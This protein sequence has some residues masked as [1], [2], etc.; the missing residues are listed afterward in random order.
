T[1]RL[2]IEDPFA[3]A[4]ASLVQG[5]RQALVVYPRLV[6]LTRLFS[7]GRAQ[8]QDGRRLLL[9]RPTGYELHGVREYVEG[10]SL[11]NVH[12]RSTARSLPARSSSWSSARGSTFR[13]STGSCSARSRGGGR[14]SSTWRRRPALN[15]SCFGSNRPASRWPSCGQGTISLRRWEG[16]EHRLRRTLA[17]SLS[18]AVVLAIVWL[19]LESPAG[20]PLAALGVTALALLPALVRPPAA[21]LAASIV[22]LGGAGCIAFDVSPL[23]PA[24]APSLVGHAFANGFLDFY[25]VRTPFDPRVHTEMRGVVLGA[26]FG[27]VLAL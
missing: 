12:W 15:R 14:R 13:S 11:R 1:V 19:R 10:E 17:V 2:T 23:H 6:S 8:T 9:R 25:D 22:A 7:E 27:F 18:P 16:V 24:T 20:R 4:R 21:R 26:V 3:L 5:E